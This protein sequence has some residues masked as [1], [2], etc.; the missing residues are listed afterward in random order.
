MFPLEM[1]TVRTWPVSQLQ[2]ILQHPLRASGQL[3]VQEQASRHWGS[4]K[5]IRPQGMQAG[6]WKPSSPHGSGKAKGNMNV[7]PAASAMQLH[8]SEGSTSARP[9]R[10]NFRHKLGVHVRPCPVL[11]VAWLP[12][13]SFPLGT[14]PA[15]AVRMTH[16]SLASDS[17]SHCL[18]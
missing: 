16:H 4:E 7:I 3:C 14:S 18:L 6:S 8:P 13:N 5:A 10:R 2:L 17:N 11:S 1:L 9:R 12:Q 15:P